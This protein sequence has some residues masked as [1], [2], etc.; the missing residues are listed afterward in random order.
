M[1]IGPQLRK[2]MATQSIEHKTEVQLKVQKMLKKKTNTVKNY[3]KLKAKR[4]KLLKKAARI[5]KLMDQMRSDLDIFE[6]SD[7]DDDDEVDPEAKQIAKMVV[8]W[9]PPQ[10]N[11]KQ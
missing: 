8:D 4:K 6:S 5:K 1:I 9:V 11:K 3:E 2:V 7:S 10:D